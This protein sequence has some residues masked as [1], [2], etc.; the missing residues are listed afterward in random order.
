MLPREFADKYGVNA[1][2]LAKLLD[3]SISSAQKWLAPNSDRDVPPYIQSAL[4]C[5]DDQMGLW[6][7]IAEAQAKSPI[8]TLIFESWLDK[9]R[10][11]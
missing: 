4:D 7:I 6:L 10:K 5:H 1:E 3:V 11:T 9:T 2:T 8:R